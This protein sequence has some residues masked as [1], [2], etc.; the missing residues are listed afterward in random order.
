MQENYKEILAIVAKWEGGYSNHPDDPGGPTMHGVIQVEYDKWRTKWGKPKQSVK[1]ITPDEEAIIWND[2]W[3]GVKG[4]KLK[5]GVDLTCHDYGVNSGLG[6]NGQFVGRIIGGNTKSH[7]VTDAEVDSLNKLN[8][9]DV[10]K[11]YNDMRLSFLQGLKTFKSFGKG[12]TARVADVRAKSLVMAAKGDSSVLR[13]DAKE[14]EQKA[15]EQV[16]KAVKTATGGITTSGSSVAVGSVSNYD[17]TPLLVLGG[18]LL[19]VTIA[20]AV[21]FAMKANQHTT[22]A[23]VVNTEA[24]KMDTLNA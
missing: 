9:V 17:W 16:S 18:S 1:L 21:I 2:Y 22:V 10:I 19:V 6:R 4:P 7:V 12:W 11:K 3:Q 8:S 20:V 24:D 15:S 5:S 14:N 23:E 13:Q